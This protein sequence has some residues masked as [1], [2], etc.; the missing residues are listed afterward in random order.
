MYKYLTISLLFT[1]RFSF[2]QFHPPA[3]VAGTNAINKDSSVFVNWANTCQLIRGYKNIAAPDSG[4]A[5][6]GDSTSAIGIA[7]I[8]GVVSLGD[9]GIATLQFPNPIKDGPSYDFAVFEN[10]FSD[11]YLELAFVEVSSDGINFFRFPAT[12]LIQYST[13]CGTFGLTDATKINNLAGKYRMNFGTP[14][15]LNELY[16]TIG[17]DINAVTHIRIIDAIGSIDNNFATYDS[18]GNKINDPWPTAFPSSGFDLDAVGVIHQQTEIGFNENN[19]SS[20]SIKIYQCKNQMIIELEDNTSALT[21]ISISSI[22]GNTIYRSDFN[23]VLESL[24]KYSIEHS[25][26]TTGIYVVKLLFSNGHSTTKKIYID[27]EK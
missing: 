22:Y 3:D 27:S 17:L 21:E 8:N 25:H 1:L 11:D 18:S 16:G 5:S 19:F 14:F 10:S 6:V 12:S 2:S 4:L 13:Q 9:G 7:G 23:K 24:N 20:L 26:L 15:D